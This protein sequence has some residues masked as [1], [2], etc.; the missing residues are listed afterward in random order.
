LVHACCG[1][2]NEGEEEGGRLVLLGRSSSSHSRWPA[3]STRGGQAVFAAVL[4]TF[5]ASSP[6]DSAAPAIHRSRILAPAEHQSSTLCVL[7]PLQI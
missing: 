1:H 5:T 3:R 6:A 4:P 2:G 7:C